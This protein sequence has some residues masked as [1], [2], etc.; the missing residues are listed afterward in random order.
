MKDRKWYILIVL[1]LIAIISIAVLSNGNHEGEADPEPIDHL[2]CDLEY[3][4]PIYLCLG[5]SVEFNH[6]GHSTDEKVASLIG[7]RLIGLSAGH[8]QIIIDECSSYHVYVSDLYTLPVLDNGKPFLECGVYSEEDNELLDEVLASKIRAAGYHTRAGV[9][10]AARFLTLCLNYRMKYC[11]ENGRLSSSYNID[12]EGR[13]YHEGLYLSEYKYDDI[14][15]STGNGPVC[16]GCSL[17]YADGHHAPNG[18]DCSGFVAWAL[19]NGGYDCGDIGAGPTDV[20]D[21]TD[22]GEKKS[23]R[24]VS[25][26]EIKVGDLVG[27]NGH[28]GII[29]GDDGESIYIAESYWY[30]DMN[31]EAY[32]YKD[33][34]SGKEWFYVMLMDSYYEEDGN[35]TDYW[36]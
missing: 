13:Y 31:V 3:H 35:L 8:A 24:K 36:E 16:W 11:Y 6:G 20:L 4:E 34:L 32:S 5:E 33:I 15:R 29:I 21:F 27:F 18:L 7:N 19:L 28:I 10:E 1:A 25:I 22:L 14:G 2:V 23:L 12:G 17:K 9:V 26:E 30:G